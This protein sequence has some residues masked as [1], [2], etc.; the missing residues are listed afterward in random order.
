[1]DQCLP[2]TGD[3]VVLQLGLG[4]DW[5]CLS[6]TGQ[7]PWGNVLATGS[8][9]H[10]SR[11][12]D[13]QLLPHPKAAS[14]LVLPTLRLE[15]WVGSLG[16]SPASAGLHSWWLGWWSVCLLIDQSVDIE[17]AR[18]SAVV[19]DRLFLEC[20]QMNGQMHT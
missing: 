19:C 3:S 1:M 17:R 2:Q 16:A 20:V 5:N 4:C 18:P 15:G 14:G 11:I 8:W 6:F 10:S 9:A 12:R 7:H 13:S